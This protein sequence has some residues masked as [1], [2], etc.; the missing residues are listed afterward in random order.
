MVDYLLNVAVGIA[1]GVGALTSAFP[2]LY[3]YT[4]VLC[5]LILAAITIVNLRGTR[6]S[7]A[8]WSIPTY[9]FV[10]ALALVLA[11]GIWMLMR[12]EQPIIRPPAVPNGSEGLGLWL[13]VRAFAS[14]CTAMTGVEAVSNGV[15]A[16][17]EPRVR[18]AH[19][20]LALIVIILA[21]LLLGIAAAAHGFGIMAMDQTKPGYES[22]LSQLA[23]ATWGRGLVY[24]VCIG[25][26]LAVLCLSANTSFVGFPRLCRM[27]AEDRY[28]PQAFALPGRRLVYT[29][30]IAFLTV[31]AGT[32]LIAFG[33]ITDR[34]IPLFAVGAFLAF[35]L[36]QAGMAAH[37][38]T[39]VRQDRAKAPRTRIKLAINAVGA[40]STGS[41]L[42]II[43]AAKFLEGAWVTLLVIPAALLLLVCIRRYYDDLDRQILAGSQRLIDARRREAPVV[44][45]PIKRWDRVARRAIEYSLHISPDVTALHLAAL[46]GPDVDEQEDALRRDWREFVELPASK[47]R[48]PAPRLKIIN[49]EYR[50]MAA[51]LLREIGSIRKES[52]TRPVTVILPELVEGRWWG[53]LMHANRERRLRSKLLRAVRGIAVCTVPWQLNEAEADGIIAAEEPECVG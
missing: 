33:G 34:L 13:I 6:E 42:V 46:E 18:R 26:V 28:L 10:A 15:G 19:S 30:G 21:I 41:A 50:S 45:V 43:V 39:R 35:T 51:P 23:S 16:F 32:L 22:V 52:P 14:G 9:M 47:V 38:L 29:A 1:A 49:S 2:S 48:M 12:G 24:Y 8:A 11:T 25:A 53:Y 5:L 3:P 27:I 37:W 36:S 7:G 44:I 20:T 17:A 31:G 4:L 40:V